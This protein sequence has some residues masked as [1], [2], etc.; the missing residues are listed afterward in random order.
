[1]DPREMVNRRTLVGGPAPE[2]VREQ[3]A[4]S[5]GLLK[6][7]R[8]RVEAR[9]LRLAKAANRLERAIDELIQR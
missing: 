5:R 9:R 1:M 3:I 4:E 8:P 6:Q 2:R 7:N